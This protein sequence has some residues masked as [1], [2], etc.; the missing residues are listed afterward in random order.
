MPSMLPFP[1]I[2]GVGDLMYCVIV[3]RLS[4]KI[5]PSWRRE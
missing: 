5:V 4:I 2:D 1:K 3:Q